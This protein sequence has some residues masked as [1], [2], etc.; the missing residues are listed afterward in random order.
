MKIN[1][2][3]LKKIFIWSPMISHVGTIKASIG[4]ANSFIDLDIWI[5]VASSGLVAFSILLGRGLSRPLGGLMLIG[6]AAYVV[7]LFIGS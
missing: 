5:L 7:H 3:S 2:V 6:Y 1:K 4:I